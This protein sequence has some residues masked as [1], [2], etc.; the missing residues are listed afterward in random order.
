MPA[1]VAL[2]GVVVPRD[3][4]VVSVYDRGFLYGDTVFETLRTYGGRPHLLDRHLA[5]LAA[6]AALVG[7]ALPVG[8]DA[9]EAE[10][11]RA[12]DASGETDALLRITLSRGEGPLGLDP[13]R[14]LVPR[15]VVFV[16]PLSPAPLRA[17][18]E[19]LSASIVRTRRAS[20]LVPEAKTGAYLD[21]VVALRQAASAGADE[22]I[23]VDP[24]GDVVEASA[25][26]VFAILA[27]SGAPPRPGEGEGARAAGPVVLVTPPEGALLP[28]ITRACVLELARASGLPCEERRLTEV[29]LRHANEVFL[30]SSVRE[31]A[32]VVAIDG[33]TVGSGRPGLITRRLHEAYRAA[34]GA[35]PLG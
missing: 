1:V 29:E 26:N 13:S 3:R 20:D 21:A 17:W 6:S 35:P 10:T 27:P 23:I 34:A 28:G 33:V 14:A 32:G 24:H 5:R 25:S 11:L 22:A 12:L 31:L 19:G 9:L 4:A 8:L 16:E 18:G 30:T 15:R 2:D 7:L